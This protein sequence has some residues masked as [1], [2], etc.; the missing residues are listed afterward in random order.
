MKNLPAR[1]ASSLAMT[2]PAPTE[3]HRALAIRQDTTTSA[4]AT[5]LS[6][7]LPLTTI[8]TPPASCFDMKFGVMLDGTVSGNPSAFRDYSA[9]VQSCY[10][11][12]YS[13]LELSTGLWFSPGVCPSGYA[14]ASQGADIA[15]GNPSLTLAWCCPSSMGYSWDGTNDFC[16]SYVAT[17]TEVYSGTYTT[18]VPFSNFVALQ[19]PIS[20]MWREEDLSLFSPASAPIL[21][22]ASTTSASESTEPGTRTSTRTQGTSGGASLTSASIPSIPTTSA[23]S[24]TSS[25]PASGALGKGAQVGI[26]VGVAV[27][28]V[29]LLGLGLWFYLYRRKTKRGKAGGSSDSPIGGTGQ[30]PFGMKAEL[31][32][33][34]SHSMR[35]HGAEKRGLLQHGELAELEPQR[36]GLNELEEQNKRMDPVELPGNAIGE[37]AAAEV[38]GV[39]SP[40][41]R[42]WE[43][44]ESQIAARKS[45]RDPLVGDTS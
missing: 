10:P 29:A 39:Q 24:A 9:A 5:G 21:A 25:G 20:V 35:G 37:N 13:E 42:G 22:G 33:Q 11:E 40:A 3:V 30:Q 28:V 15:D 6:T 43:T 2:T 18:G 8:F 38:S 27:P 17:P 32:G 16:S 19:W 41:E 12:S 36:D 14:K 1:A 44:T 4:A 26:G 31:P 45:S 23:P 7:N 34:E